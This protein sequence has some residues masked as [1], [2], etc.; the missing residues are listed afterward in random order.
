MGAATTRQSE[1][2][3]AVA[4]AIW[5]T[6]APV[7][8]DAGDKARGLAAVPLVIAHRGASG[9]R[10]EHTL[11]AY[12]L[13]IEQGAD[14][15]E[16]DLVS[17]KD[18]VLVAR[19]ENEISGTTDVSAHPEFAA[20]RTTKVV[21]G[22]SESGWFTED[23]TLAELKTL[24]ARERLPQLRGTSF[25]DRFRVPTLQEVIDLVAVMNGRLHREGAQRIGIYPETKHPTYFDGIG[26][27][28][29]EPLIRTLAANGLNV[30]GAP[31]FIQSFESAN[32]RQLRA[33]T[34]LPLIQ[35]IAAEGSSK[36]LLT[37]AGLAG[38][39][40]YAKG[41]GVDKN[42]IV[43]RDAGNH[44]LAPTT[45][46]RDAHAAGLW[47]HGWTFRA[48]NNFLPVDFRIGT[49]PAALG[50]LA[51][52]ITLFLELGIDGIF[53]DFPGIGV[54]VRDRFEK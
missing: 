22:V 10:P 47:V 1:R 54:A 31:V 48:E 4:V 23:F 24:Y 39:A 53:T 11:E 43:P 8:A 32:L 30:E 18:G 3:L 28:L 29:E 33:M 21:D 25:D 12:R 36:D 20:R 50:D 26:L 34:P 45:L 42:L 17:T 14:S 27:S 44:L 19:H 38:I 15:V 5:G 9:Q 6:L 51:G 40:K 7:S 37:P 49:D 41:I 35:L 52:E 46:I 13:A 2:I 16:P